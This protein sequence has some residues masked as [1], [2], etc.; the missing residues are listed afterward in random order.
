[1]ALT[2]GSPTDLV[3]LEKLQQRVWGCPAEEVVPAHL[4]QAHQH[5]GACLLEARLQGQLVGM[6]YAFPSSPGNHYLYSHL[7]AIAPEF[8]GQ[9]YGRQLKQ[10]QANWAKDHGYK[11]I[12]WTYDPLQPGN[13]WLNITRL[14]AVSNRYLVN[15]YGELDDQ[16]NRGQP[17]D[18]LEVDWWLEPVLKEPVH[19]TISFELGNRSHQQTRELFLD[20]FERGLSVI[21]FEIQ[22]QQGVYSLGVVH[23][24]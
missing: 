10:A 15:Y 14:G 7:T 5:H 2:F 19:E 20:A 1:M 9:G 4:L 3:A 24:H 18:R 22:A 13:A 12:V 23:A 6:A 11:R 8:Q 16:L 17:T 21:H